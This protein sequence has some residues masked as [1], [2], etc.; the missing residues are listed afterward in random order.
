MRFYKL[1]FLYSSFNTGYS[2]TSPIKWVAT[3]FG[4]GSAIQG[5]SL[6]WIAIGAIFYFIFCMGVGFLCFKYGWIDAVNEVSNRYNPFVKEMRKK[7]IR[8]GGKR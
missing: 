1:A 3:A 7:V 4:I 6:M 2:V 5:Y 8:L